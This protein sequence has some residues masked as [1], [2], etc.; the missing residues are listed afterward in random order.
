MDTYRPYN[1][2]IHLL[3]NYNDIRDWPKANG[4]HKG[5]LRIGWAG[6]FSHEGNH[7]TQVEIVKAL[8]KKY[9]K[10]ITFHFMGAAPT[11]LA[12]E[13]PKQAFTLIPGV[14]DMWGYPQ[15]LADQAFDIGLAPLKATI[16]SEAKGHGKWMEYA[17][18]KIPMVGTDWGPYHR[19]C[20]TSQIAS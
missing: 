2:N 5:P 4:T 11:G 7:K 10:R 17:A 14:L 8:W 15:A 18:L 1:R 9:G 19:E 6:S 16:F 3:K 20:K 13:L 12:L